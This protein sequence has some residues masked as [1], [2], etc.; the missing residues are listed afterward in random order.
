MT[1]SSGEGITQ[2]L[3]AWSEGDT[4][5]RDRLMPLVYAELRRMANRHMAREGRGRTIQT[6]ALVHEAYLRLVDQER[7][8]WNDR[9]HFFAIAAELMRRILVDHA[10]KRRNTKRGGDVTRL[11]LAVASAVSGERAAEVIALDDA[12]K[13]LSGL[14]ERKGRVVEL[15]FFGGLSIEE[16]AD[17]LGI[18]PGTVMRDWTLSKAWLRREIGGTGHD[19]S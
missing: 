16:T 17:V 11:P 18:S 4:A 15:R 8:R 2:L 6:T 14:D 19:E 5:A 10:R 9:A 3:Q 12:L 7:V 1:T 13:S